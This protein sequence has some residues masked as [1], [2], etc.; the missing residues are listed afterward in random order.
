MEAERMVEQELAQ[1]EAANPGSDDGLP[2]DTDQTPLN[3]A[4]DVVDSSETVGFANVLPESSTPTAIGDTN[5]ELTS[6]PDVPARAVEPPDASKD[7]GD[8]G[9]EIVLEGEEDTVIY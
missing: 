5:P 2:L 8:N 3:G 6:T 9:G 1:F 4:D 7:H